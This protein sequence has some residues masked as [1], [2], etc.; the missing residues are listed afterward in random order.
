M[1]FSGFS[2][3]A[4]DL[5]QDL[6]GRDK[7]WFTANRAA[8]DRELANPSRALVEAVTTALQRGQF[9]EIVGLPKVNGSIAPI[10]RDIRFSPDKTLYK[11][12]LFFKWW[13]GPVKQTAPTLYLHLDSETVGFAT[14]MVLPSLDEWRSR[15]DHGPSGTALAEALA[16]LIA[17][18]DAEVVGADYQRVP[19]PYPADHPRADLLR[20]KWFQ[21][22]WML[23]IPDHID[24][25]AFAPW[26]AEQLSLGG[27]VHRWLVANL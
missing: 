15:I 16:A 22:R 9:P 17:R 20:H 4:L 18:T 27:D 8:Y 5:L 6:P 11:D 19:K 21:V 14:G 7:A 3:A 13:E 24:S 1:T 10:H 2:Q 26:C 25:P 12:H 23:P